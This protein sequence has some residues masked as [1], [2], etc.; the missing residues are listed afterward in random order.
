MGRDRELAELTA[1]LDDALGGMGRL[2]LLAGEPG[3]G[4]T[5]LT[6]QLAAQATERGALPVWGRCWEGGGAPPFWPWAQIIEAVAVGC[7]DQT[8]VAWLG[9]G[10]AAVAQMAPGIG[11]RLGPATGQPAGQPASAPAPS[12][13]S[14]AARFSLFQTISAFLKRAAAVQP[15][16]LIFEDL[17]AADDASL[18]LL[19]YLARDL[20]GARLFLLGTYRDAEV[21]RLPGISDSVSELV[22]EGHLTTLRGLPLADVRDLI[23]ELAGSA[24]SAATVAAVHETT[25]GNPLFVREAVRLLASSGTIDGRG[26]PAVPIPGQRRGPSFSNGLRRSP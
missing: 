18:L 5:G 12:I 19:R 14:D 11:F 7:D 21:A 22:R 16:V 26:R 15:L 8:L 17:H 25:E 4:K 2:F 3:I 13:T 10:A 23:G 1:G 24:P 6:E 20:R 9:P